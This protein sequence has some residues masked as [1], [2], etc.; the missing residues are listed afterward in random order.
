MRA[1]ARLRCFVWFLVFLVPSLARPEAPAKPS[2]QPVRLTPQ[3]KREIGKIVGQFRLAKRGEHEKRKEA[4]EAAIAYGPL[5]MAPMFDAVGREVSPQLQRY[6][7]M[8]FKQASAVAGGQIAKANPQEVQTLRQKVLELQKREDLTKEMIERDG[9]PSLKRLEEIFVVDREQVLKESE[10]LRAER[11]RL[12]EVGA[13][14]EQCAVYLWEQLPDDENRPKD[15][16]SFEQY[17]QGEEALAAGLAAPM[18][19]KTREV[20]ATNA[21]LAAK[22][23]PEEA[24]AILALNLMRNLLGLRPVLIDV[25]LCEAARDHSNDMLTHKFFAHDSPLPGKKTPWDR[26]KRFNTSA[27]AENIAAGASDGRA[28]NLIWFHSPG[29]HKNMLAPHARVG[30]G[31]A[32]GLYTEMFGD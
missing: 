21:R 11:D 18:D 10:S 14:W 24:R 1:I 15:K 16:P 13:L 27:S 17:L 5:A 7:G 26:A 4:V 19:P 8:F 23:D 28:A 3:Q 29:H 12:Q 31:R 22:L 30:M 9:D 25:A 32:G 20:L 6:G 2:P